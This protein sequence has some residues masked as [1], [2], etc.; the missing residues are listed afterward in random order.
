MKTRSRTVLGIES[1]ECRSTPAILVNPTTVTYVD[2]DDDLVTIKTTKGSFVLADFVF[3][4]LGGG[5]D[6]LQR[7]Q[8]ANKFEFH[9]AKI[10]VT[11]TAAAGG[12]GF[13]NVGFINADEIDLA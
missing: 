4:P 8:L 6:L 1:L 3:L 7:V 12:D 2:S 9:G 5:R 13:V 11:S 10:T